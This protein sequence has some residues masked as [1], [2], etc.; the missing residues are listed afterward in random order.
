MRS[1]P[2]IAPALMLIDI[3]QLPTYQATMEEDAKE[4]RWDD[5]E[6][7]L[8]LYKPVE[9]GDEETGLLH[10]Q[11]EH[12]ADPVASGNEP[13]KPGDAIIEMH[14]E[15]AAQPQ[16]FSVRLA[17][18]K[19]ESLHPL[20]KGALVLVAAPVVAAG[21]VLWGTGNILLGL[22]DILTGGPW[23]RRKIA[24]HVRSLV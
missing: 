9:A 16:S 22:G 7:A 11:E 20:V 15:P 1:T 17:N 8:V 14:E 21:G 10:D 13:N 24:Q 19:L 4:V 2:T 23:L 3:P 6:Q 5:V 12:V 18:T